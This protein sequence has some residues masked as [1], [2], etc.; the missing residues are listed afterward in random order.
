M[1]TE[2]LWYL[3][4]TVH[5]ANVMEISLA[6]SLEEIFWCSREYICGYRPT[7]PA[8]LQSAKQTTFS[9]RLYPPR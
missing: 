1:I 9:V 3:E 8:M 7:A 2:F 4:S 5:D 6:V